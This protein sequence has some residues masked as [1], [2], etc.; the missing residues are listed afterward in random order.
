MPVGPGKYDKECEEILLRDHAD[1]VLVI[2]IG[3]KR[4]DGFSLSGVNP[5]V[6]PNI[7]AILRHVADSIE[8]TLRQKGQ[9]NGN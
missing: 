5:F 9:N 3:G 7:A 6:I 1:V 4:G 8:Q 2:V